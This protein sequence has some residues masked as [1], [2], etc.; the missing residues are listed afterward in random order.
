ML[1]KKIYPNTNVK[2]HHI[3]IMQLSRLY[4]LLNITFCFCELFLVVVL[5]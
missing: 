1:N 5:A 3:I 2:H 4:F